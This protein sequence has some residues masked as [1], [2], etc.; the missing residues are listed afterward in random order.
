MVNVIWL[1]AANYIITPSFKH[2]SI[3][4]LFERKSCQLFS[5]KSN[6]FLN[7]ENIGKPY[8]NQWESDPPKLPLPHCDLY[9]I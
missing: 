8:S 4:I 3:D 5:H 7:H 1:K 6:M 2:K 9:P